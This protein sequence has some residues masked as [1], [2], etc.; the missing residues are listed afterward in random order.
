ME[1]SDLYISDLRKSIMNELSSALS[2]MSN[3]DEESKIAFVS[4][5]LKMSKCFIEGSTE[6]CILLFPYKDGIAISS[7][8]ANE[9]DVADL[10][11]RANTAVMGMVTHNAPE[12][13]HMN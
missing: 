6:M 5:I 11:L 1:N 3:L 4:N 2:V 8:N 7:M 9:F 12:K 13:E 10:V